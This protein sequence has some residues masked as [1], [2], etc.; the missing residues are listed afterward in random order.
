MAPVLFIAR[1][2]VSEDVR[3][4]GSAARGVVAKQCAGRGL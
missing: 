1:E 2:R 3:V 4:Q